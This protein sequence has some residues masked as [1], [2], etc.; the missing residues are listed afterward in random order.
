MQNWSWHGFQTSGWWLSNFRIYNLFF[1][2]QLGAI[3]RRDYEGAAAL[4]PSDKEPME[5]RIG[6]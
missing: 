1:G 3:Y 5:V 6:V 2:K 4:L